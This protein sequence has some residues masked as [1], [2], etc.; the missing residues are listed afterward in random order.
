MRFR[1][2]N[3]LSLSREIGVAHTTVAGWLAGKKT[4]VES[5]RKVA[6]ALNVDAQ[7]MLTGFGEMIPQAHD[8]RIEE[9]PTE[10]KKHSITSGPAEAAKAMPDEELVALIANHANKLK[11]DPIYMRGAHAEIIAAFATELALRKP[12]ATK[13]IK[14]TK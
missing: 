13:Q 7:W 9:Q 14:Y 3:N 2:K 8:S 1:G 6:G 11:S 12:M 10:Y 5:M 4:D